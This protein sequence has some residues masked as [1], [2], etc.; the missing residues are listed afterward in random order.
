VI[1]FYA[2]L[3]EPAKLPRI[4]IEIYHQAKALHGD[5]QRILVQLGE[6]EN[7]TFLLPSIS[8]SFENP[9]LIAAAY[10]KIESFDYTDW[11]EYQQLRNSFHIIAPSQ[12]WP[13]N[14]KISLN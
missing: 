3:Q 8:G 9:E 13:G 7:P 11:A 14:K 5:Q 12:A 10:A 6:E 2:D 1:K 4:P